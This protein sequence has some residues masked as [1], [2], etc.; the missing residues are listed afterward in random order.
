MRTYIKNKLTTA[1]ATLGM[2]GTSSG[3][4]IFEASP[5]NTTLGNNEL[6]GLGTLTGTP[7]D[8][9]FQNNGS[10]FNL[11]GFSST[12]NINTLNGTPITD[13]DTVTLTISVASFSV[14]ALRANGVSFGL[15]NDAAAVISID[16]AGDNII[17]LEA[18]NAGGDIFNF[19]D[20]S[21]ID[22]GFTSTTAE[23]TNGF[24]ATLVADV[25]GFTY[26][27]ESVGNT[28]PLTVSGSFSGTEFVDTVG[29]AHFSFSQQQF[30]AANNGVNL[31]SN[32]TEARIEVIPEPSSTAL[33]GLAGLAFI[34]RRRK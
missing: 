15:D 17:R 29:S 21:S 7:G 9:D 10:G 11:S 32:I 6:G 3:A 23:L 28:S 12:D 30:N 1:I 5:T 24:T 26:T 22:T 18:S 31:L 13:S 16:D 19:L 34:M 4:V 25:D 27:L 8:L 14:G 2:A 20:G 33:L